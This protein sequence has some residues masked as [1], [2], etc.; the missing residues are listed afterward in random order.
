MVIDRLEKIPFA[1]LEEIGIS[2]K[3]FLSYS[4]DELSRL[5][6]GRLSDLKE[7]G[8]DDKKINSKFCF[9]EVDGEVK[10]ILFPSFPEMKDTIGL[11]Q[12][13]KDALNRGDIILKVLP[14]KHG[15]YEDHLIQLDKET[16]NLLKSNCKN[17]FIPSNI[18]N[19]Q[20]GSN[21]VETLRQGKAIELEVN[22]SK[23]T[24][25][26]DLKAA[27]PF[28]MINGDVNDWKQ[29][30]AEEWDRLTPGKIGFLKTD[31]NYNEYQETIN[32]NRYGNTEEEKNTL[33][34]TR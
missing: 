31:Q 2:K 3:E 12:E 34:I 32:K 4:K 18:E 10:L 24:C 29:K 30:Q 7:I 33:K 6:L 19:V 27:N 25:G 5:L 21:Q 16:N 11:K 28:K 20:L 13:E 1:Q 15:K 9:K 17:I 23:V 8:I 14:N 22:G 26:I